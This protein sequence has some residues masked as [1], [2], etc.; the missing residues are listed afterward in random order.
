MVKIVKIQ[1]T[2]PEGKVLKRKYTEG[3]VRIKKWIDEGWEE[4]KSKAKAKATSKK[5]K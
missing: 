3:D 2:T 1:F 5:K 4:E